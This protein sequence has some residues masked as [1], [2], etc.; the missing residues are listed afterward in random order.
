M[1]FTLEIGQIS[2]IWN[3]LKY[4]KWY[5]CFFVSLLSCSLW[6][7]N[8]AFLIYACS[9][10]LY[11]VYFPLV[12]LHIMLL[13]V[14]TTVGDVKVLSFLN[15]SPF[16]TCWQL[17]WEWGKIEQFFRV[18]VT[19]KWKYIYCCN[20]MKV[21]SLWHVSESLWCKCGRIFSERFMPQVWIWAERTRPWLWTYRKPPPI[22]KSRVS[23]KSQE[24]NSE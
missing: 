22:I 23:R 17:S 16:V 20:L 10:F 7:W 12:A 1:R 13:L 24:G 18:R 19:L 9:S 8:V 14:V 3:I 6:K 4:Y 2:S 5:Y 15:F 11:S 21:A